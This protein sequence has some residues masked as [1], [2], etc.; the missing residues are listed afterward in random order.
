MLPESLAILVHVN[1]RGML[2]DVLS[3][4]GGRLNRLSFGR[5]LLNSEIPGYPRG[6]KIHGAK[7]IY[8]RSAINC[9]QGCKGKQ[10]L[11]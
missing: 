11:V 7:Y 4:A 2:S 1:R 8:P 9:R 6:A 10:S 5:V 3:T